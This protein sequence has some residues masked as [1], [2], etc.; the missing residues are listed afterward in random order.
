[1]DVCLL[2]EVTLKLDKKIVSGVK[3]IIRI[4]MRNRRTIS[5]S[6]LV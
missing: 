3:N 5:R 2:E 1:M 6:Q 4:R